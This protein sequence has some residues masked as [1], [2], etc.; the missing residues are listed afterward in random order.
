MKDNSFVLNHCVKSAK[1]KA[2][3]PLYAVALFP[4]NNGVSPIPPTEY[5]SS[6]IFCSS[7]ENVS[8]N[9]LSNL[10]NEM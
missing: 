10:K 5:F 6:I 7:K 8:V 1:K 3:E 9:H 4:K 2:A